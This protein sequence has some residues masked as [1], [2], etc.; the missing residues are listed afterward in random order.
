MSSWLFVNHIC[1][2]AR[3]TNHMKVNLQHANFVRFN[4]A[5]RKKNVYLTVY[6]GQGRKIF[7]LSSRSEKRLS[8]SSRF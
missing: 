2:K 6:A 8:A 4:L 1:N 5:S 7:C 3:N